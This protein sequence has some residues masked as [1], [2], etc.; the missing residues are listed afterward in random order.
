M[1][2]K[3]TNYITFALYLDEHLKTKSNETFKQS[4]S[5]P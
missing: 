3:N 2:V 1:K 4:S 5:D